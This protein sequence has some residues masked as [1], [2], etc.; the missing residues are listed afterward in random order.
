[1][2]ERPRKKNVWGEWAFLSLFYLAQIILFT[3]F[4]ARITTP[5]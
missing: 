3:A 4:I 5:G 1:M 2:T